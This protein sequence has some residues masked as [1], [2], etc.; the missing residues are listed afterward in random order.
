MI[1]AGSG[2]AGK[3]GLGGVV[4]DV[5]GDGGQRAAYDTRLRPAADTSGPAGL[6]NHRNP[7]MTSHRPSGEP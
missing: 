7:V 3:P 1:E 4:V 2:G 5:L 6:D